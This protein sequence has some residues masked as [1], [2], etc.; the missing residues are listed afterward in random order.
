MSAESAENVSWLWLSALRVWGSVTIVFTGKFVY[1]A[2]H[3]TLVRL[4]P[5]PLSVDEEGRWFEHS[6]S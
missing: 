6:V 3:F 4:N 2:H 1:M 5:L